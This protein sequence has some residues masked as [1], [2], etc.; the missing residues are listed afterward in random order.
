MTITETAPDTEPDPATVS[1]LEALATGT[2][3]L[4]LGRV[5]AAAGG[6]FLLLCLVVGI[7]VGIERINLDGADLCG[8]GDEVVQFWSFY[9]V[10]LVLLALVPLLIGLATAVIP[11]QVGASSIV[12][13]R[14]AA[15]ALWTWWIGAAVTAVGFLAAGLGR[16]GPRH[17]EHGG[18]RRAGGGLRR[19]EHVERLLDVGPQQEKTRNVLRATQR[20]VQ[21]NHEQLWRRYMHTAF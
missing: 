1:W 14:A 2:D 6:L 11:L 10:G 19:A 21:A 16:L 15:L 8:S 3:H 12:F 17:A 7:L 20:V 18:R 5:W 4:F 9:R 13:P